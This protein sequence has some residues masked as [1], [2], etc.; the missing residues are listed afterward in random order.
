MFSPSQSSHWSRLFTGSHSLYRSGKSWQLYSRSPSS[1]VCLGQNQ[2]W[3]F[4]FWPM[5]DCHATKT[6]VV[7]VD[8]TYGVQHMEFS[9]SMLCCVVHRFVGSRL[10]R[11]NS[12]ASPM[13]NKLYSSQY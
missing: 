7:T 4:S 10:D 3:Q 2:W 5:S 13:Y 8:T 9:I 12:K 11:L 1:T 6:W